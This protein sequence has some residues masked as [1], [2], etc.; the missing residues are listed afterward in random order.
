MSIGAYRQLKPREEFM[1]HK[2]IRDQ[3]KKIRVL[4]KENERLRHRLKSGKAMV[5]ANLGQ[6]RKLLEQVF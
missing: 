5:V 1:Q 6:H 4:E 2:I 3:D